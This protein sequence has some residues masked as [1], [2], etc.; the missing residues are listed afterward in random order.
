MIYRFKKTNLGFIFYSF[1]VFKSY[2][3]IIRYN[4]IHP[5]EK[6]NNTTQRDVT[7]FSDVV[8]NI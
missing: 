3:V 1:M 6:L 2:K 4:L 5:T 8:I 7:V